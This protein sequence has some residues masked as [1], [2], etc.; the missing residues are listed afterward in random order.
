MAAGAIENSPVG[1]AVGDVARRELTEEQMERVVRAEI[2]EREAA[3]RTYERT[4][5]AERTGAAAEAARLR[6]EAALLARLCLR[7]S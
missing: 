2:A 7:E 3:A 5:S 6:R 4:A 1:L